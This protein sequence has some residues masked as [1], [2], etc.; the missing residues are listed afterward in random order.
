MNALRLFSIG[1]VVAAGIGCDD[2]VPDTCDPAGGAIALNVAA[3]GHTTSGDCQIG[4]GRG[5]SYTLLLASP[6]VVRFTL[7]GTGH[8]DFNVLDLARSVASRPLI[9]EGGMSNETLYASLPAG[10]FTLQIMM[11]GGESAS[12]SLLP[13]AADPAATSGCVSKN[14]SQPIYVV[15]EASLQGSLTTDDCTDGSSHYVDY[16]GVYMAANQTRAISVPGTAG[17]S[18]SILDG[19]NVVGGQSSDAG[20]VFVR[21]TPS[22]A[23]FYRVTVSTREPLTTASYTIRVD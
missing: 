13:T 9:A 20:G 10:I 23:G 11:S 17:M 12:Y 8:I 22:H 3:I 18:V 2:P 16:M 4:T 19:D 6:T 5:D 1:A 7:T 15:P 14:G 21:F